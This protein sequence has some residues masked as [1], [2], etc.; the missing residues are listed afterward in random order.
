MA[1]DRYIYP[2]IFDYADDGISVEFPDLQG[3]LTFGSD[4]EDALSMA[5][6]AMALHL[7]GMEEDND[8][9]PVPSKA[10]SIK[11][12]PNQVLVLVEAWMP[13]FRLEM[14]NKAIKNSHYSSMAR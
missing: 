5:K 4:D 11:V 2:A 9:I 12:Q 14:K 8:P 10:S 7:F 3:C 1:K 6:E 13:P